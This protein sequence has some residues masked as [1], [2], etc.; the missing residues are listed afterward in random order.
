MGK[1]RRKRRGRE[2]GRASK[3]GSHEA[4]PKSA[5]VQNLKAQ[6]PRFPPLLTPAIVPQA[7]SFLIIHQKDLKNLPEAVILLNTVSYKESIQIKIS[8]R[9]RHVRQGLGRF[10]MQSF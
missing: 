2:G 9:K 6:S 3:Q 4:F 10:Q 5:K 1:E 7:F 8:Q